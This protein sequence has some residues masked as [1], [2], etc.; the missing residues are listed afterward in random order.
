[1][2][3]SERDIKKCAQGAEVKRGLPVTGSDAANASG[4][5]K[6]WLKSNGVIA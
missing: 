4:A 1:M 6:S 3:G 2:G 5:V